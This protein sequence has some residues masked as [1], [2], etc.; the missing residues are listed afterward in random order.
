MSVTATL[1]HQGANH[2]RYLVVATT[3]GGFTFTTTGAATPDLLTDSVAG[4]LKNIASA[5][6]NGYGQLAAGAKTQAQSRGLWLSDNAAGA[7]LASGN[8]GLPLARVTVTKRSGD[9]SEPNIDADV[10]G[11]GH[12]TVKVDCQSITNSWSAYVDFEIDAAIGD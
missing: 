4:P 2:L 5:F 7:I 3:A 8:L 10:D 12:P 1:V 6:A 11:S 9:I